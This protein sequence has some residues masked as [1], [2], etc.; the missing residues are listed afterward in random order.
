MKQVRG[1]LEGKLDH[2][3]SLMS[4]RSPNFIDVD[5]VRRKTLDKV[6][7]MRKDVVRAVE[8]WVGIMRD[9]LLQNMGINDM[10]STKKEM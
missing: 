6:E 8:E 7:E 9:H 2:I 4:N 10:I 1:E 5:E 3:A